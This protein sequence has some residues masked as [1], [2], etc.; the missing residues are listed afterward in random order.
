VPRE[1]YDEAARHFDARELAH[2]IWQIAAINAWNRIAVA[3]R[4]LPA[5]EQS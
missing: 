4:Q 3:T 5:G 2:L 1:V